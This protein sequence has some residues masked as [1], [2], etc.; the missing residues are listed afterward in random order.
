MFRVAGK[1]KSMCFG[2]TPSMFEIEV[3]GENGGLRP[4][5]EQCASSGSHA[6]LRAMEVY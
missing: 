5:L 2:K 6:S 4:S 3:R 1:R